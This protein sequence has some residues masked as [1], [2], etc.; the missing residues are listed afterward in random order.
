MMTAIEDFTQGTRR[1]LCLVMAVLIVGAGLTLASAV[2][3]SAFRTAQ[4]H[5]PTHFA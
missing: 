1:S 3:D 2:A 4:A 5:T